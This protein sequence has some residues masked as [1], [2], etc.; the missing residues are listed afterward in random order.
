ML[1]LDKLYG[2]YG[3]SRC[4]VDVEST[5]QHGLTMRS[6][7]ILGLRKQ[8][9]TTNKDII[10]YDFYNANNI[11][12]IDRKDPKVDMS[13]FEKPYMELPEELYDKY[14]LKN[15]VLEVLK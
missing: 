1:P 5:G 4:V 8:F 7:E 10:H 2:I 13:F 9:V 15:W 6:I 12:V 14:S 11:L 3:D